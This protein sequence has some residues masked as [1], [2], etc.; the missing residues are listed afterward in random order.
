MQI[1]CER[2]SN[3]P[4][5]DLDAPCIAKFYPLL[6]ED[7]R[8]RVP[9]A[10]V[11]HIFTEAYG[12]KQSD[13]DFEQLLKQELVKLAG[14]LFISFPE[15][16]NDLAWTSDEAG[17]PDCV[18]PR[19][20]PGDSYC[21]PAAI[22]WVPELA[23][24]SELINVKRIMKAIEIN[25]FLQ[26][27]NKAL[28]AVPFRERALQIF[29]DEKAL[30]SEIK[31]NALFDG[32]LPLS[33]IGAFELGPPMIFQASGERSLPI[34]IVENYHTY[35]SLC[36]WNATARRY[37]VVVFGGGRE[38]NK[39]PKGLML[40]QTEFDAG[41][42]EYFGDIDYEGLRIAAKLS[43]SFGCKNP[44]LPAKDF[45]DW[46][47]KHGIRRA[48]KSEPMN[49]ETFQRSLRW[50]DGI[51]LQYGITQLFREDKWIPQESLG[52]EGLLQDF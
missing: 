34:L 13:E 52:M 50:L 14:M 49:N 18:F 9:M 36:K 19:I 29:G 3:A 32:H 47:L 25:K 5:F 27:N 26:S 20:R 12:K 21:N 41:N 10:C 8:K 44:V 46:L 1:G 23:F 6:M 39:V 11:R 37:S 40:L 48:K 24:C 51:A 16:I 30:D 22:D 38:I 45:Y 43:A 17:L 35:W 42:F 31:D 15:R 33:V 28:Q 2:S 7:G 4:R